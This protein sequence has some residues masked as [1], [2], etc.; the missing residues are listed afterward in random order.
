MTLPTSMTSGG[1]SLRQ[2]GIRVDV[3]PGDPT[4]WTEI[5]ASSSTAFQSSRTVK[6]KRAPSDSNLVTVDFHFPFSTRTYFTRARHFKTGYTT[7]PWSGVASDQPAYFV[8]TIPHPANM[9]TRI[10][11]LHNVQGSMLP[12]IGPATAFFSFNDGVTAGLGF[13]SFDWASQTLRYP[14]GSTVTIPAGSSMPKPA[15]PTLTA[16]GGGAQGAR[17]VFVRVAYMK[18]G[19]LYPV[20]AENSIALLA[21][22]RVIITA[23]PAQAGMDGW[24]W[25]GFGTNA[26]Y[27]Q[28]TT[29]V[30]F[31]TNVTADTAAVVN[32]QWTASWLNMTMVNLAASTQY[33]FY[34]FY[35][36]ELTYMRFPGA[37]NAAKSGTSAQ[38]Q[39]GD[40]NIAVSGFGSFAVTLPGNGAT[41]SGTAGVSKYL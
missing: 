17:T 35:D 28:T 7:G 13:I 30:A 33:F 1:Y 27:V 6:I 8:E 31:G 24:T 16:T 2:A 15:A 9:A 12:V 25:L 11:S 14:D 20:S 41:A 38:L 32:A 21:N 4:F 26:E 29:P 23:P 19:N 37:A 3:Y 22:Q 36:Q 5:Q 34:P 18:D 40:K 10:S 39:N